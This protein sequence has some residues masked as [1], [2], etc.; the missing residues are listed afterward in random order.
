MY[1]NNNALT[2][3]IPALTGLSNLNYFNASNN[4][5]TGSIPALT[6]LSSLS[7]FAANNNLL[8]R[9]DS[10]AFRSREVVLLFRQ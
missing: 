3:T 2:G 8:V 7:S 1:V 4:Q 6:G 9:I 5:L 10:V